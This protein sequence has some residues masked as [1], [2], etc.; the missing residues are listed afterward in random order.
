MKTDK[1]LQS[2][3]WAGSN[4][5]SFGLASWNISE[6][7]IRIGGGGMGMMLNSGA[8]ALNHEQ[9]A[10]WRNTILSAPDITTAAQQIL[11]SLNK[12]NREG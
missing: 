9:F 4:I 8:R 2:T 5:T 10:L 3:C 6:L 1:D 7:F 11:E 12:Q